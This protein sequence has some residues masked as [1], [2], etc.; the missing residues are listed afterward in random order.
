MKHKDK[1]LT[2]F[3]TH[4]NQYFGGTVRPDLNLNIVVETKE[5]RQ[6]KTTHSFIKL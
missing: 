6:W 3:S 5:Q 4:T 1:L 2:V